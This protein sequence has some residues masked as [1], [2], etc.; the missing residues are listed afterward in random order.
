MEFSHLPVRA[1]TGAFILNSG[2]SKRNLEGQAA[3]QMQ[4]GR[5]LRFPRWASSSRR[6]SSGSCRARRWRLGRRCWCRSFRR[7]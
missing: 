1:A 6:S 3:E 4:A 2:L 7:P 5:L